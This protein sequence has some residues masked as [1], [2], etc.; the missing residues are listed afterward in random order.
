MI[1]R[2]KKN[3]IRFVIRVIILFSLLISF[4]LVVSIRLWQFQI[5]AEIPNSTEFGVVILL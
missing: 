2:F 4:L 5:T 3:P 1:S